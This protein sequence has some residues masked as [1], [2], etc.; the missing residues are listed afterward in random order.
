MKHPTNKIRL[1]DD[2]TGFECTMSTNLLD[3]L[4]EYQLEKLIELSCELNS[5]P[6]AKKPGYQTKSCV[7]IAQKVIELGSG[8]PL[9]RCVL[10]FMLGNDL[11]PDQTFEYV[12]DDE[13]E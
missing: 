9:D 13:G 1:S 7:S 11:I 3:Q 4:V 2:N 6:E 10:A 12:D 5:S 8:T